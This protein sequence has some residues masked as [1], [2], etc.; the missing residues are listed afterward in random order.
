VGKIEKMQQICHKLQNQLEEKCV[1]EAIIKI[2]LSA[3]K[4]K[5]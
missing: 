5:N 2:E 4:L 3:I 1:S